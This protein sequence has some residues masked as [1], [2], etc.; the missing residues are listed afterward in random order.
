M[1]F[2]WTVWVFYSFQVF[3][4]SLDIWGWISGSLLYLLCSKVPPL[5]LSLLFPAL[6]DSVKTASTKQMFHYWLYFYMKSIE[7]SNTCLPFLSKIFWMYWTHWNIQIL[8]PMLCLDI[9]KKVPTSLSI[10]TPWERGERDFPFFFLIWGGKTLKEW[11]FLHFPIFFPPALHLVC[12][13]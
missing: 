8:I 13:T 1:L 4:F 5:P 12:I 3:P 6:K 2:I 10:S 11:A 9:H 7:N